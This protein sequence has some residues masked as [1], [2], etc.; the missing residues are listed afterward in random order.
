MNTIYRTGSGE[1]QTIA[2]AISELS[3]GGQFADTLRS[4]L[5][6]TA[7]GVGIVALHFTSTP[8]GRLNT[9]GLWTHFNQSEETRAK[10]VGLTFG[11]DGSCTLQLEPPVLLDEARAAVIG[12]HRDTL[13]W[14]SGT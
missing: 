1:T 11:E 14:S 5:P 9:W 13:L 7:T 12:V 10:N 2:L 4:V 3:E 8:D 6:D